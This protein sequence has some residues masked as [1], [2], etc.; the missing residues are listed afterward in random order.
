VTKWAN[1][2]ENG[3]DEILHGPVTGVSFAF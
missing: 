2:R 1:G 3:V